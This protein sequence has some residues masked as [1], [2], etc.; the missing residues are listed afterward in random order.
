M[1]IAAL[2]TSCRKLAI[3]IVLVGQHFST[4]AKNSLLLIVPKHSRLF[5][6]KC[7]Q[8]AHVMS[9]TALRIFKQSESHK[10]LN[11]ARHFFGTPEINCLDNSC[12][13]VGLQAQ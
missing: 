9:N 5:G 1:I 2:S 11:K 7:L 13:N 12:I 3:F 8:S 6:D 4:I 10:S